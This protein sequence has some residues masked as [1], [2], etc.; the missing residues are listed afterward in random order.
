M[1]KYHRFHLVNPSPWP[2]LASA[3]TLSLV[4]SFV[5]C[6]HDYA[7]SFDG[8]VASMVNLIG[9]AAAWWRDVI[10]EATFGGHH[11]VP[12]QRGLRLGFTLF[13]VSEGMLFFSLFWAFFYLATAPGVEIGGVWPPAGIEVIPAD[14]VP[15]LNTYLLVWSGITL[16]WSHFGLLS[17][18]VTPALGGLF[19]TL[20]LGFCFLGLQAAEYYGAPFDI[21][22]GVYGSTFYLLTGFHG[23]HVV[24]GWV[25]LGVCLCRMRAWH[26]TAERHL[27]Y[28]MAIW[29]WHFVD[30]IW[31]G[32]YLAVYVW[33]GAH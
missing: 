22:D 7:G 8:F 9:V 4:V 13:L 1:N 33:G 19:A 24:I 12:V 18:R 6:L 29:Y 31:L 11:T 15:L 26:F 30:V 3:A 21:S 32:L 25:F 10:R 2:L 5:G 14:G 20:G 17:N 23:L 27:G 16:T 28:E